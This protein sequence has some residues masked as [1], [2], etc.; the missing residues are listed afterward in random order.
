MANFN[1]QEIL[2]FI[3]ETDDLVLLRNKL[4]DL[5]EY[6]LS[7]VF[8]ALSDYDL[9]KIHSLFTD[10]EIGEIIAYVDSDDALAIIEPLGDK[11]IASIINTMEPDDAIDVIQELD[12]EKQTTIFKLLGDEQKEE[13]AELS[14][15][16][17]NTAG[18][19]M[20]TNFISITKGSDIK[21]I[22]KEIVA[23]A[24][25]VESITTSFVVD[26]NNNLLGT[27][28]L[29]KIIKTKSPT[30]VD[31]IMDTNFVHVNI[32]DNLEHVTSIIKKYDI[33]N[34]PV[35][36]YG[37]LKGIIT[38][39][40]ALDAFYE[41]SEDDYIK[42]AAVTDVGEA[43][44]TI[45]LSVKNR[46]P[47]LVLLLFLNI[48]I[49]IVIS[50]FD[51]IFQIDVL[52]ILVVF[53]PLI[54]GLAGNCGTQ[55]LA[56]TI[57]EIAKDKLNNKSK[58]TIHILKEFLIG[59]FTGIIIASI[60]ILIAYLVLNNSNST[61]EF[62]DVI[63]TITIALSVS[64]VSANLFGTIIPIVFYKIKIDPAAASGPLITTIIDIIAIVIYYTLATLL[65]YNQI[66]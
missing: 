15:Y 36:K 35:L 20:N 18:S 38:M 21:K 50:R 48:A 49:A 26:E 30:K 33:Y 2:D 61:L 22:M 65:L 44:D 24:P 12:E 43:T 41:E 64:I 1:L 40:D 9:I 31:D 37:I 63:L 29:K 8:L 46:L 5:H 7:Q 32:D 45:L 51:Y 57:S 13:I 27:L 62:K 19:I 10:E 54:L 16:E 6:E 25:E 53:Q 58:I 23:R 39:D 28:D 4:L 52:S 42:F 66:I 11:Q 56:V 34:L 47:W 55:S 17:E 14:T 60:S 59:I 3:S